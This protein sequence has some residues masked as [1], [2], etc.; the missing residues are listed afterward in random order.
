MEKSFQNDLGRLVLRVFF[1]LSMCIAHG[2]GK[3]EFFFSGSEIQFLDP[4]GIGAKY[5][6]L[7]A[8]LSEFVFPLLIAVGLFTRISTLPV[9]AT[10]LVAFTMVHFNDPY[11][12]QEMALVY[13]FAFTAILLLGPGRLSIDTLFRGKK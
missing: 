8:G 4:I 3:L 9:I 12:K 7:L 13:L 11:P 6:L 2:V 5:S 10:M 1:G